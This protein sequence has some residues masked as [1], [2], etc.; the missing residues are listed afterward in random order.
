MEDGGA[1]PK[2][3]LRNALRSVDSH[4][5]FE[6]DDEFAGKVSD[7]VFRLVGFKSWTLAKEALLPPHCFAGLL[8]VGERG[9]QRS[10]E[11]GWQRGPFRRSRF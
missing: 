4:Q 3:L 9:E 5:G 8:A 10:R 6:L 11:V 1:R 2:E 7:L